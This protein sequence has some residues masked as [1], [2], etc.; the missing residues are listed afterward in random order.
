MSTRSSKPALIVVD[1]QEDFCEPNGSLAIKG[2]RE[3]APIIN[4]LLNESAFVLK[5]ATQDWHP[6]DHISFASQH[7]GENA[8]ESKYDMKNPE[9]EGEMQTMFVRISRSMDMGT[10]PVNV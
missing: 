10:T 4:S 3:L 5:I 2:A 7:E 9:N 1:M 6:M 8:F